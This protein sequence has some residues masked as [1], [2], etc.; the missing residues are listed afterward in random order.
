[1]K[2]DKKIVFVYSYENFI[3]LF[4]LEFIFVL[5]IHEVLSRFKI[6]LVYIYIYIYKAIFHTFVLQ[7]SV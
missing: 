2:I 3:H 1:M 7:M 4:I 5:L 6:N